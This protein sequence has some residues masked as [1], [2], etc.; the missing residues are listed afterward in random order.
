M[1]RPLLA[2]VIL[3]AAS[4]CGADATPERPAP[5]PPPLSPV[6]AHLKAGRE[7]FQKKHY[8]DALG[9]FSAA[10]LL[11]PDHKD[12]RFL[13][14]LA[15]YWSR[16]PDVALE[17]WNALLDKAKR[18]TAEEWEIERHR[19]M[20]LSALGQF[21]A[22]EQ[23]VARLYELRRDVKL[24]AALDARG[25]VREHLYVK[26]YR[27]G[28]WE[29]F[30]D[31]G[32]V[33]ELW[34]FPVV[35]KLADEGAKV[36]L[37]AVQAMALPGGGV[38]YTLTEEGA[39]Y[40]RTYKRWLKRPDY[41]EVRALV[42]QALE[43]SLK[44]LEQTVVE[45]PG[46]FAADK[47]AGDRPKPEKPAPT[48]AAP[49]RVWTEKEQSLAGQVQAL[50]LAPEVAR[51]L[52]IAARLRDVEFDVTRLSRLSLTDPELAKRHLTGLE[53]RSP[54]AQEDAAEL[55][56]LMSRAKPEH[57]EALYAQLPKLGARQ[58]Y[59]E[60]VLL[61][62]M[63]TRGEK[64]PDARLRQTLASPDF[65]VRQTAALIAARQGDAQGLAL[66]FKALEKADWPASSI[67]GVSLEELLGNAL[68]ALPRD[69]EDEDALKKWQ[70]Q[71]ARWWKD[72]AGVLK[73]TA[74]PKPG[75]PYWVRP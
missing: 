54:Y 41:S 64:I 66:L 18:K 63:N 7:F 21:D 56:D 73:Y 46:E 31:R 23:V 43:G 49:V 39:G 28:C 20:A 58:A 52:T 17:Y 8:V 50:G 34:T 48:P 47:P 37:L 42:L 5:A 2:A 53:R 27:A 45:N 70:K 61:T 35:F 9:E 67:L 55:V 74:D 10:L 26:D 72:Y 60:F 1:R 11:K 57:L 22:A 38:G 65:M 13:A 75:Q 29:V 25:F 14:G 15:A 51:M 32:E 40:R 6:D 30:D 59:L 36:K 24:K 33:Q 69:S 68:T 19:V 16:Q 3:C 12:A 71:A 44:P 4:L 62:A